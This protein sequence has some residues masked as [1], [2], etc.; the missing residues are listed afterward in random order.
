LIASV[1]I[2]CPWD[3]AAGQDIGAAE[4]HLAEV[5]GL[6]QVGQHVRIATATRGQLEGILAS[7]QDAE[8]MLIADSEPMQIPFQDVQRLWAR[9]HAAGTGALVG[10]GVGT[11]LG[12]ATGWFVGEVIC[13]NPDCQAS[14]A[15]TIATF[16]LIGAGAGAGSG[17]L[18]GLAIPSWHLR[19]P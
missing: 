15:G 8:L 5:V 11:V 6:L 19:F 9:G 14:T 18:I 10:L 12:A 13:D 4:E 2:A 1:V 16:G 7:R 3:Y 17:A